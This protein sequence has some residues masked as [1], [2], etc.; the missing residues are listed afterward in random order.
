MVLQD[1]WTAKILHNYVQ[2]IDYI[3]LDE[4]VHQPPVEHA[5][6]VSFVL[7]SNPEIN[8]HIH[9]NIILVSKYICF[10]SEIIY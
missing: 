9:V 3:L 8:N 1:Q 4:H 6:S 10:I 5:S 7:L 2:Q